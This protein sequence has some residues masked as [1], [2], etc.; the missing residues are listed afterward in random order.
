M[1]CFVVR[2]WTLMCCICWYVF[3]ADATKAGKGNTRLEIIKDGVDVTEHCIMKE[4]YNNFYK[5]HFN[6]PSPG[7]Y[8]VHVLF[9]ETEVRGVYTCQR[10]TCF[11]LLRVWILLETLDSFMWGSYPVSLWNIG[12]SCLEVLEVF[13]SQWKLKSCYMTLTLSPI[14]PFCSRRH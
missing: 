1:F 8:N 14:Q 11:C 13:Y 4:E 12:G 3:T 5:L 10:I 2:G 9:N 7:H 6:P